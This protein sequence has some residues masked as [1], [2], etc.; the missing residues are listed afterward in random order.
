L[1]KIHFRTEL[2]NTWKFAETGKKTD[3]NVTW[4][5]NIHHPVD[6]MS[7]TSQTNIMLLRTASCIGHLIGCATIQPSV[8]TVIQH[9]FSTDSNKITTED[10]SIYGVLAAPKFFKEIFQRVQAPASKPRRH[11]LSIQA[12]N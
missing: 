11:K 4:I 3:T 5:N 8:P 9:N 12:Y 6:N 2:Y 10:F 7:W 1:L